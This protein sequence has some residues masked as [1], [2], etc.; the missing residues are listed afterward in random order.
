VRDAELGRRLVDKLVQVWLFSGEDAWILV[1]VEVQSQQE[2]GFAQRMY[3][4]NYRIFD[5][6]KR[7]V[8]SL[9]V[10]G[11]ERSRWRPRRFKQG[12]WGC[13]TQFTY[14]VIKLLDYRKRR[15]ELETSDNPFATVVLAHL[16][17]QETRRNPARRQRAKLALIRRLYERGYSRERILSLFRFIDW[18]LALPQELE[19]GVWQEI[20]KY[21]EER[22]MPY[23]TSV[24]RIGIRK[25]RE[26]G[27]E[28]GRQQGLQQ[29]L[30]QGQD[31][32]KREALRT[33]LRARFQAIPEVIEARIAA[34]DGEALNQLLVRAGTVQSVDEI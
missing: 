18:L 3:V 31:E 19:D 17:A 13:S 30:Q 21:E 24:E 28:E 14:P 23:I 32:G 4:Y 16:A 20:E 27:L 22:K 6:F 29:G 2:A 12:R 11:D 34:A 33:I 10:L 25:G 15:N 26:E 1:H 5:R 8:V 9:A 7:E